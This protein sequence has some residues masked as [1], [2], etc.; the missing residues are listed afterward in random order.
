MKKKN[1]IILLVSIAVVVG[2]VALITFVATSTAETTMETEEV[3]SEDDAQ[4]EGAVGTAD[5][6]I[7][8]TLV[9]QT[10]SQDEVQ[11]NLGK[12]QKFEMSSEGCERGVY[13]GRFYY[14][15]FTIF[16]KTYNKGQ[17]FSIVSINE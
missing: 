12:W 11:E 16:S 2:I 15:D 10:L 7:A 9:G 6:E 13:A 3:M 4:S 14:E 5:I 8:K 1:I 17:T